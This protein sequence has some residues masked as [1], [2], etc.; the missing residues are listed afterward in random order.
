MPSTAAVLLW[1]VF[2]LPH[3]SATEDAE[4]G[5]GVD[6]PWMRK[7]A[8]CS[9]VDAARQPLFCRC[10]ERRIVRAFLSSGT[11]R[12]TVKRQ[13]CR[14]RS[15]D[16][17]HLKVHGRALG[18]YFDVRC[19]LLVVEWR[20]GD[21]GSG[22]LSQT[23]RALSPASQPLSLEPRPGRLALPNPGM[24]I[25]LGMK[26]RPQASPVARIPTGS[27]G[28]TRVPALLGSSQTF[29][30]RADRPALCTVPTQRRKLRSGWRE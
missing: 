14:R 4:E 10:L 11:Q 18:R 27:P 26:V 15:V 29:K 13:S 20:R 21:Q 30:R 12:Q 5:C 23:R 9:V 16:S 28:A 19:L 7:A 1:L 22:L 3:R 8:E 2:L 6:C 25:A 24:T 17:G